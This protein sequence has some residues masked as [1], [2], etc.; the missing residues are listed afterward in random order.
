MTG[1]HGGQIESEISW[2]G[3]R[4]FSKATARSP[5]EV[6]AL[7]HLRAVGRPTRRLCRGFSYPA[8]EL[9][10]TLSARAHMVHRQ[11][12]VIQMISA[13]FSHVRAHYACVR[14]RARGRL[15]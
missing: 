10:T 8:T 13:R 1:Q 11:G 3:S 5:S 9:P 6:D 14:T 7:S 12:K 2:T 15:N 4:A